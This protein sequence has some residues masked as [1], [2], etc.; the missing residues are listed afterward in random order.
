M[1]LAGILGLCALLH[2]PAWGAVGSSASLFA[3]RSEGRISQQIFSPEPA[4][5][6]GQAAG[7]TTSPEQAKPDTSQP[8]NPETKPPN[9]IQ[10]QPPPVTPG[11]VPKEPA[12][13]KK[14]TSTSKKRPSKN[15][16]TTPAA[17]QEAQKKVIH[18][19]GTAEPNA[20]LTPS[21]TEE[22]AARQRQNTNDLLASTDASL[23]K[24]SGRQ[25]TQD[26]QE[27][28]GQI[29]KFMQQVKEA[30]KE[31]D[32]QRAYK[33]AVKAHLLSDALTKP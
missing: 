2:V 5:V 28:V 30:D 27:T 21:I 13:Q 23:Q 12:K 9:G 33:L 29:R 18:R 14:K 16:H 1:Y 10:E 31:G 8:S 7:Q 11:T 4:A 32:P 19:G 17:G 6:P 15:Q 20:Q 24:L 22:Q 3:L 26:E 25:L